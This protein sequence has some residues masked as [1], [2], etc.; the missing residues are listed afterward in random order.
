MGFPIDLSVE[1]GQVEYPLRPT[2]RFVT[3]IPGGLDQGF[4]ILNYDARPILD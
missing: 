2:V 3:P 1:Q 4:L